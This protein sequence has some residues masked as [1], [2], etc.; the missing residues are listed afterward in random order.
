VSALEKQ[1]RENRFRL[2]SSIIGQ[3]PDVRRDGFRI[4][5]S[6]GC[7]K[8][9]EAQVLGGSMAALRGNRSADVY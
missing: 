6:P 8:M 7:S 4:A 5:D 1:I 2:I 3:L 9:V